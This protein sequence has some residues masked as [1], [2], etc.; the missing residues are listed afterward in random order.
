M[1]L[2][3]KTELAVMCGLSD[4]QKGWYK[5]VLTGIGESLLTGD[6][7]AMGENDWRKLLNLLLQ[8]RK[9]RP[10]PTSQ[11][12]KPP[13]TIVIAWLMSPTFPSPSPN[14]PSPFS[15]GLQP[16]LPHEQ[17]RVHPGGGAGGVEWQAQGARPY[18]A[19]P[20]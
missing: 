9:V 1:Q 19:T 10:S 16:P 6:K 17:R 20:S 2:P 3:S 15:P 13:M 8:L 18:A 14:L 7:A 12:T 5:R 11:T 4:I